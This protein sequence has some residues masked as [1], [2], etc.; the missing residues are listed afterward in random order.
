MIET[1]V[2][3]SKKK[4][5]D[6][7]PIGTDCD[8][9]L[10]STIKSSNHPRVLKK[11]TKKARAKSTT[12]QPP[13]SFIT[14]IPLSKPNSTLDLN[15]N[16]REEKRK[17]SKVERFPSFDLEKGT[18]ISSVGSVHRLPNLTGLWIKTCCTQASG[19]IPRELNGFKSIQQMMVGQKNL[20]DRME[21]CQI[22]D[23][24]SFEDRLKINSVERM[25]MGQFP[26]SKLRT[27]Q[28]ELALEID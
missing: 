24:F 22:S 4:K 20:N 3:P 26:L 25:V 28:E 19:L 2:R 8:P 13:T 17:S 6:K 18:I 12:I 21:M 9:L 14:S 27:E 11:L 16:K 7:T 1:T 5:Q 10:P 23:G 15:L